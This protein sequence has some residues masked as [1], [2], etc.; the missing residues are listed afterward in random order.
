M[1]DKKRSSTSIQS[2][3]RAAQILLAVAEE[4]TG[5]LATDVA[6]KFKLTL[7]TSFHLLSTLAEV[8]LLAK[9]AGRRYVLGAASE[10]IA[11]SIS[12]QIRPK[13]SYLEALER[14]AALTNESTYLTGWHMG[15]LRILANVE[16]SQALRVSGL[17]VGFSGSVHA[18]ASSKLLLAF[19]DAGIREE[20]L[21][22][23]KFE[24]YTGNTITSREAFDV[25]LDKIRVE[26]LAHDREEYHEGV[27]T[28]SAPIWSGNRVVAAL[29]VSAPV[30]RF[31]EH[32]AKITA[33]LRAEAKAASS[34]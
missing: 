5:L 10:Q 18:R 11:N 22:S 24:K 23:Y 16:G 21:S 26:G 6:A 28:L 19:A 9:V 15:Q 8:G 25:E 1:T 3:E 29:A 32:Q 2:V 30:A 14:L 31:I 33:T 7:S 17:E 20:I 27:Y 12:R 34:H 13:E 4:P